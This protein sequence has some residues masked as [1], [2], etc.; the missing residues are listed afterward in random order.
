MRDDANDCTNAQE[1]SLC[2][3]LDAT[4]TFSFVH[5]HTVFSENKTCLLLT[6]ISISLS[7]Q[8][9]FYD[10]QVHKTIGLASTHMSPSAN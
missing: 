2:D 7:T 6:E 10:T 5:G 3:Q 8:D 1:T 4:V 9:K